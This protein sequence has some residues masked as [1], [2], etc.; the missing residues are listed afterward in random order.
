MR[1]PRLPAR[2]SYAAARP[3]P[4][5]T[6]EAGPTV[7]GWAPRLALLVLAPALLLLAASRNDLAPTLVTTVVVGCTALLVLRPTPA[8]AGVTV[9]LAG[10][11]LWGFGSR[12]ESGFDP[13]AL[14]V[15][16]LAYILVRATWWAAHLPAHGHAEIAALATG[17]RRDAVVLA[18][19]S[20]LGALAL[21][22]SG[23]AL[24]GAVL[25][26]ALA[27]LGL[28]FVALATGRDARDDGNH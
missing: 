8:T 20:L 18:G 1:F 16:L 6:V 15:A 13:A 24:P 3:L 21:L 22:A 5:I 12:P 27:V 19:T 7:P 14:A 4:Q 28:A 23:T 17:W 10:V 9:V 2:L 25:L 26:A 11:F